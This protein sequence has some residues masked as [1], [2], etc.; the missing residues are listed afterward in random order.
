MMMFLFGF[1]TAVFV[2]IIYSVLAINP[3][4]EEYYCK[5]REDVED[6]REGTET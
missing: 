5:Y 2:G 3:R 6:E 1:V 4:D